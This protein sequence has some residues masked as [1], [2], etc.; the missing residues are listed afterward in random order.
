[1]YE[2]PPILRGTEQQQ[3]Q[4]L[5]DYLVRTVQSLEKRLDELEAQMQ[6]HREE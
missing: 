2:L 6:A 4:A 5:R 3:L 1:M